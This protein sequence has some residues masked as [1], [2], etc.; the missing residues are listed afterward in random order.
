MLKAQVMAN[1]KVMITKVIKYM[2]THWVDC[3]DLE[4][5]DVVINQVDPKD[6][7]DQWLLSS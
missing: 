1:Q 6:P 2:E 5:L 3:K 7:W 4:D